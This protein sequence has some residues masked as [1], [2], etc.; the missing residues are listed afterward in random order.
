MSE[1]KDKTLSLLETLVK[2]NGDMIVM[3]S[4]IEDPVERNRMLDK[5]DQQI[6]RSRKT[7]KELK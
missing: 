1:V 2:Q 3:A 6:D 4:R 5:I 7:L